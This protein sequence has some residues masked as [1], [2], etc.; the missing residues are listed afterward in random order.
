M[1]IKISRCLLTLFAALL[2]SL[3]SSGAWAEMSKNTVTLSAELGFDGYY[4]D[5]KWTQIKVT[6]S[7][8]D[9]EIHGS[10]SLSSKSQPYTYERPIVIPAGQTVTSIIEVPGLL[11][12]NQMSVELLANNEILKKVTPSKSTQMAGILIGTIGDPGLFQF[13]STKN[14]GNAVNVVRPMQSSDIVTASGLEAMDVLV[15]NNLSSNTLTSKQINVIRKWVEMGG[16]L[17]IGS[18]PKQAAALEAFGDML[19][20]HANG[21]KQ[22]QTD[23]FSGFSV[24]PPKGG[25]LSISN[26]ENI[27]GTILV[28][29]EGSILAASNSIGAGH[30]LQTAFDLGAE[31]LTSWRDYQDF[32]AR[33]LVFVQPKW[34]KGVVNNTPI[35]NLSNASQYLPQLKFPSLGIMAVG[36][37]GYVLLAG[38]LVYFVLRRKDKREWAW[39]VLPAFA[40]LVSAGVLI[41]GKAERVEGAINQAAGIVEIANPH[42]A[43][44]EASHSITVPKGGDYQIVSSADYGSLQPM[45]NGSVGDSSNTFVSSGPDQ[46]QTINYK[47]V[48]YMTLRS[49][50]VKG[51]IQNAGYI[52]GSLRYQNHILEG[53]II[54]RSRFNLH[55][56]RVLMGSRVVVLPDLPTG[57]SQQ[58]KILLDE[59]PLTRSQNVSSYPREVLPVGIDTTSINQRYYQIMEYSALTHPFVNGTITLLGWTEDSIDMVSVQGVLNNRGA[60]YLVRQELTIDAPAGEAVTIPSDILSSRIVNQSGIVDWGIPYRNPVLGQGSIIYQTQVQSFKPIKIKKVT[61]LPTDTSTTIQMKLY[62][63]RTGEWEVLK[64]GEVTLTEGQIHDYLKDQNVINVQIVNKGTTPQA[65]SEPQIYVE[66]EVLK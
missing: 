53:T 60:F 64:A 30:V 20:F 61:I 66:G 21:E 27:K 19:P 12:N 5:S 32:W 6:A 50:V 43:K 57:K 8:K 14:M 44:V 28:Q 4:K 7:S 65:V 9:K 42:F 3:H 25:T 37:T 55:D 63:W 26:V 62:N 22:I 39:V 47:S 16:T 29:D 51:S 59:H 11:V 52:E 34:S 49:A 31:Q 36:V 10:I 38:P 13:F 40:V 33:L 41:T 15:V 17:I 46:K 1:K 35:W 54:N 45:S 48:E 58:V 56:V 23:A 24:N 18:S 2:L